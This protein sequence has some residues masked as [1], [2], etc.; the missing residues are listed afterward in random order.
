MFGHSPVRPDQ[1]KESGLQ[2]LREALV[3]RFPELSESDRLYLEDYPKFIQ[4]YKSQRLKYVY[5]K[6]ILNIPHL[7]RVNL[8]FCY[9][10]GHPINIRLRDSFLNVP[11]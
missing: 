4:N 6:I 1:E 9:A 11:C 5:L 3:F 8:V 2:N 10:V 7:L